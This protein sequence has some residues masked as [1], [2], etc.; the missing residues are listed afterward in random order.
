MF[1]CSAKRNLAVLL[2]S[3]L[4]LLLQAGSAGAAVVLRGSASGINTGLPT[5]GTAGVLTIARPATARPGMVM[6]VSIAARPSRMTWGTPAG[7]G[8]T[9]L[10][11]TSEQPNGGVNTA[12]GGMTMR[13]Y[14]RIV[15]LNEPTSYTWT[16]ANPSNSGG[17]AV[18]GMLVFSGIDTATNPINGTPTSI[19]TASNTVFRTAPVTTTVPNAVMISVLSVLS[20]DSFGAPV[21]LPS[22][23][24]TPTNATHVSAIT[25]VIDRS[26]PTARDVAGTTV[27]MSYFTQV[28]AGVSCATEATIATASYADNGVGHLMALRP[29]LRDLSLDMTRNV[30]LSAGGTASYT[31]TVENEGSMPEPGPLAIVNTLPAGLSYTGFSGA[32]WTCSAAGQVVTCNKTGELAAGARAVPLVLNVSIAAGASGVITNSAV[33]SGTGGDS[34]SD[35][36]TATETYAML[37]TPYA[38]YAMDEATNATSFANTAS[39]TS[40]PAGALGGARAAGNPPPIGQAVAGSQGTCGAAIIPSGAANG[41]N[42]GITPNTLGPNAGSIAF[43]YA[44]SAA[45]N[46]GTP[47]VLFDAT[48]DNGNSDRYFFLA[49]DGTGKLV[50][51][52]RDGANT[53]STAVSPSYNFTANSW[54]HITVTWDLAADRLHI[55]LDGDNVPVA[56]SS[57][58]LTVVPALNTLYLGAPR[59][60]T[61]AITGAALGYSNANGANGYMDEVRIYGRA[62]AALEVVSAADLVHACV[63]TVDHY[64]LIVPATAS[65]CTPL[66]AVQVYA[67]ATAAT[68]SACSNN[69]Q[70]AVNGRTVGL[71]A[72]AGTLGNASPAFDAI[73]QANTT[74]NYPTG[75]AATVTLTIGGGAVPAPTPL[76]ATRCCVPGGACTTSNSC[77]T[78]ITPC[79]AAAISFN[80]VD[81]NYAANSYDTA[82]DHKIYTKLAGR[83]ETD[84]VNDVN[85]STFRLDIVALN[86]SGATETRY[87]GTGLTKNVT[88][89]LIDDSAG[90]TCGT[91]STCASCTKPKVA[92]ITPIAFAP[93][94]AGYR[95][96]VEIKIENSNAYRRLLARVTDSTGAAPV[97]ACSSDVFSVRPG[98]VTLDTNANAVAPSGT[99]LP[100]HIAGAAFTLS[101]R[102]SYGKNHSITLALDEGK[103]SAQN[104]ASATVDTSGTRGLLSPATSPGALLPKLTLTLNRTPAESNNVVYSEVGYLYLGIGAWRDEN[105]T[106]VDQPGDCNME[107]AGS[108]SIEINLSTGKQ[109]G[110]Y[111]CWVGTK[112]AV[113]LGRFIPHRFVTTLTPAHDGFT[114]SGEPFKTV[115]VTAMNAQGVIT[116]H[117]SG[118]MARDATLSD[119]NAVTN[120][121]TGLGALTVNGGAPVIAASKFSGGVATLSPTAATD[122]VA[123]AYKF[124]A[125]QT[126]PLEGTASLQLRA[127]TSEGVS[128]AG[129]EAGA[130]TPIRSGRIRVDNAYGSAQLPLSLPVTAQYFNGTSWVTN[131]LDTGPNGTHL[132]SAPAISSP[133]ITVTARCPLVACG[134]STDL[135]DG[136]LDLRLS[137][138]GAGYADVLLDVPAWLRYGWKSATPANPQGRAVFGIYR[139]PNRII[140]RRERY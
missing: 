119:A 105:F 139:A 82:A 90:A 30:P 27:N 134:T 116:M 104:P 44:G 61:T 8:W 108:P 78:T 43:W 58:A 67:C 107:P 46:S 93:A 129:Y 132:V 98:G 123:I 28:K 91:T 35:N 25:D 45:W 80:I 55:Y 29:S 77:T 124:T 96:D 59:L 133:G 115:Q 31:L 47:R 94:D 42:T 122:P 87:V 72:S 49:I 40:A 19:L 56:T 126:A 10:S 17:T 92:T 136:V 34:N 13:T 6:I 15:G 22:A 51:S 110:R 53:V 95:N 32:G 131:L 89:E 63:G 121:S 97:T 60:T 125:A 20:A 65:A 111:G 64:E 83:N 81:S 4:I 52:M 71:T 37:P 106:E 50:F 12:P 38:Y 138:T 33:V 26:S 9:Q 54:H 7:G 135:I 3:L 2:L 14:Y 16:F 75:G 1:F 84:Q 36:D 79:S 73:G 39:G 5:N 112:E 103:L 86:G 24:C 100:T 137:S 128:S 127:T 57:V 117:Y 48:A 11:V 102:T 41:I 21:L 130:K 76:R 62:L 85:A 18:G 69:L 113:S 70:S 101:A 68:A 88:L 23:G 109:N 118:L 99:A 114:Y 66:P 74:L 120:N 140:Y